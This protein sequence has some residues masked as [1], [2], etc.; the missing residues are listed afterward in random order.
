MNLQKDIELQVEDTDLSTPPKY[1]FFKK[2]DDID[3]EYK[4]EKN[5][6]IAEVVGISLPILILGGVLIFGH[7]DN[8]NNTVVTN[9][10]NSL[11]DISKSI[12]LMI[13]QM[14]IIFYIAAFF[15]AAKGILTFQP[16]EEGEAEIG[17]GVLFIIAA[18][19]LM[20][21]P[22]IMS[23]FMPL[24]WTIKIQTQLYYN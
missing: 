12:A 14:S 8:T 19:L 1:D 5:N 9:N 7:F 15:M 6:F 10:I 16:N 18:G 24:S 20:G 23:S 2:T 4:Q 11:E 22:T 13:N 3:I 21:L 17:S